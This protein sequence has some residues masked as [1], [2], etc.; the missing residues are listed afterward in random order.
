MPLTRDPRL[1]KPGNI[2]AAITLILTDDRMRTNDQIGVV[3]GGVLHRC[4]PLE[5]GSRTHTRFLAP[6]NP[7]SVACRNTRT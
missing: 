4:S 1:G 6:A 2:A 3:D 7:G 5:P